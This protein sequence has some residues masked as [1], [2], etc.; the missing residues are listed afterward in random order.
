MS[1]QVQLRRG[2]YTQHATF[3]GAV[4]EVTVETTNYTLRVHDGST[5]GG[6]EIVN[7]NATQ[8]LNNKT[9]VSPTF[10]GSMTVQNFAV[11]GTLTYTNA[12]TSAFTANSIV[13]KSYVD[14]VGIIF[15]I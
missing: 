5:A 13:P 7:T 10:T 12:P 8:T 9:L 6:Q 1:T 11:S 3:T 15:G 14:T 4:G 2:T